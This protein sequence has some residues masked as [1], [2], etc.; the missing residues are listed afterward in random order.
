MS[1]SALAAR[2]LD[3]GALRLLYGV[4]G[5]DAGG[6]WDEAGQEPLSD[7]ALDEAQPTEARF[8]AAEI[9]ADWAPEWVP[10]GS[11]RTVAD[12]YVRAL[13]E[14]VVPANSWGLP[15]TVGS[16]GG[17]LLALGDVVHE[18]LLPALH[19]EAPVAFSGS[20]EVSVG[21]RAKWRVSDVA[22]TLLA[23]ASG[24]QFPAEES[25]ARRDAVIAQLQESSETG[26]A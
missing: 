16:A 5:E 23:S 4:G 22:A 26:T 24:R 11:E 17:H 2:L 15:G 19:D 8:L 13:R 6:V 21:R 7:L 3:I 10:T 25:P 18:A 9:L 20:R 14:Q 1:Q 12:L